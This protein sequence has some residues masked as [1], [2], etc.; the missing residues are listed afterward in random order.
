M[1]FSKSE[2]LAWGK[3]ENPPTWAHPLHSIRVI[4]INMHAPRPRLLK[5]CRTKL[6]RIELAEGSIFLFRHTGGLYGDFSTEVNK[7]SAKERPN[8]LV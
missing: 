1:A 2:V 8:I 3:D 4:Y 6:S 5:I 7:E